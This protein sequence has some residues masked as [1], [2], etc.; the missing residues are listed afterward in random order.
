MDSELFKKLD[1]K[2]AEVKYAILDRLQ[3]AV[4]DN[5]LELID[6]LAHVYSTL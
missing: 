1:V 4:D 6:L 5:D 3:E 2:V